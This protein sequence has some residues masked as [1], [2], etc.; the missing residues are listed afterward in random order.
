[1]NEIEIIKSILSARYNM[2]ENKTFIF[3]SRAKGAHRP[4]SDLDILIM[5]KNIRPEVVS[6]LNEDFEK[7]EIPYKVELV[8]KSRIDS[9]FYDKIKAELK[10]I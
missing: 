10:E 8:L 2:S 6:Y 7:S 5:D 1:M 9:H 3:G 4:D